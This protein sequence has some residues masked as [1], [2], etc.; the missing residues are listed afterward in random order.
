VGDACNNAK[1]DKQARLAVGLRRRRK[2]H[3]VTWP[4]PSNVLG[5]LQ[6]LVSAGYSTR[7]RKYVCCCHYTR[8]II[9]LL[10]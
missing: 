8:Y 5:R 9:G 6:G 10:D 1:A 2:T 7:T 4:Q 3:T